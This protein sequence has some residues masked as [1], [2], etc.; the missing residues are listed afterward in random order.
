MKCM[1]K[2]LLGRMHQDS[3]FILALALQLRCANFIA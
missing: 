2:I 3:S 1:R